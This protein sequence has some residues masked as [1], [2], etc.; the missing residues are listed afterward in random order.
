[1]GR[2]LRSNGSINTKALEEINNVREV[3]LE[4]YLGA[5]PID[6]FAVCAPGF[7]SLAIEYLRR[8]SHFG[9]RKP[10]IDFSDQ[11]NTY[12]IASIEG[13][14]KFV[15]LLG[16]LR[17]LA[18]NIARISNDLYLYSSGPRCGISELSLPA[19]A[20]GSTIMPGKINPSMP[21]LMLQV[22]HQT[23]SIDQMACFFLCRRR[24]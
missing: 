1:M 12:Y 5:T 22:F 10:K 19:I 8:Y 18:L 14:D 16:F 3:F 20:P 4:V 17:L 11:P 24:Y 9:L 13:N 15:R 21:E 6:Q 7:S 2:R 23:M